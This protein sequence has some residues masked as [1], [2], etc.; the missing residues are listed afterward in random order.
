[1]EHI[2]EFQVE[3]TENLCGDF[4]QE[5][6]KYK[7]RPKLFDLLSK[8]QD[9]FGAL[10]PPSQSCPLVQMDIELKP[11]FQGKTIRGKGF[12]MFKV[13]L[14]CNPKNCL[15]PVWSKNWL[16]NIFPHIAHPF[17]LWTKRTPKPKRRLA[18]MS[19]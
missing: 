18:P 2:F 10:P 17:S 3:Q 14:R 4:E 11:E 8:Y 19:N 5:L 16:A 9:I 6:P 13:K 1:M 7:E 12:P 15:K